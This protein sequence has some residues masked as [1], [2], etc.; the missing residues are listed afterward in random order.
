MKFPSTLRDRLPELFGVD[1]RSLA[2]FRV[3]LA[4]VILIDFVRRLFID[5]LAFHTDWGVMPRHWLVQ[6][7]SLWRFN[8]YLLNGEPWFAALLLI[9]GILAAAAMW[10]GYRTRLAVL[11]VFLL[12]MAVQNRN[13]LVLIGGDNLIMCLLFWSLFLP[14]GARWSVDAALSTRPPPENNLHLSWA[15]AGL[16]IQVLSVYFFSAIFKHSPDW[17]PDGLAVYY[18][19]ELERYATPTGRLLLHFP[20]LMQGLTYYVYFLELIGPLVALSP[21]GTRPLRFAVMLMLMAMHVGF[22]VCMEIGHFPY[23]SLAS[24]TVLL[25]TWWWDW[26]ARRTDPS[27]VLRIYYDRDCGFCIKSCLLLREFLVLRHTE[28]FP[29]QDSARANALMQAQYSWV[30]I[31]RKDVAHTKWNAFVALLRHSSLLRWLGPVAGWRLW[32]R[33]GNAVYD[34]VARHRGRFGTASAALLPRRE[35]T[36]ECGPKLQRVAAAFVA[37]VLVWNMGT[38][39]ALPAGVNA[40]LT[41]V[42]RL[43]RLDQYWAMFAP[44]PSRADGWTVFPGV[45]EDGREVDVLQPHRP[46]NWD[47]PEYISQTHENVRWHVLRWRIWEKEYAHHREW[48]AKYLCRD[49]NA[50]A[51]PGRRLLRF[52]MTWVIER[53]VPPG[54]TP[55][56]ERVVGWRHDCV[57]PEFQPDRTPDETD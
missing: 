20:L 49:W 32:V 9:A 52:N 31:D 3:I 11:A 34:W 47:K 17:W 7:D 6:A 40:V 33:P 15:S 39:S 23:V 36:F 55:Q 14:L 24:L 43:L 44:H 13:P 38:I 35:E 51:K 19:M 10:L 56:I 12:E 54:Q 48:Y 8:L 25:G 42:F 2:L 50:R 37:L 1:L 53:S 45:L 26:A 41:P 46:L 22:I 30:V 21:W 16:L 27:G 18:T 4:S 29:A 57:A 28:I 5:F